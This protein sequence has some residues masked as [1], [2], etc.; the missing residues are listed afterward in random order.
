MS[1]GTGSNGQSG[2]YISGQGT[3]P[4]GYTMPPTMGGL[5]EEG[6]TRKLLHGAAILSLALFIC[7]AGFK[8]ARANGS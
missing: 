6:R 8:R 1:L 5:T 7:A 3:P 4:S 2:L